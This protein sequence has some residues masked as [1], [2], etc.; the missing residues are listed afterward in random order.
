MKK[1]DVTVLNSFP[2]VNE[3]LLDDLLAQE[4]ASNPMKIVVLAAGSS[5]ERDV[6]IVSGTGV[7]EALRS[8]GHQAIL[9]DAFFGAS[10]ISEDI[11]EAPFDVRSAAEKGRS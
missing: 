8:L 11:F 7:C 3:K 4:I 6:S 2:A 9:A 1:L 10:D 5:P